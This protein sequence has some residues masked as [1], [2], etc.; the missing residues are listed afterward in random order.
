MTAKKKCGITL[1]FTNALSKVVGHEHGI[2]AD[3]LQKCRK[4]IETAH[5]TIEKT[6][7][8]GKLGFAKLPYT[9][10]SEID[11]II[12]IG[13]EIAQNFSDFVVLGIGGSALGNIALHSALNHP[14]Y[15]MLKT[16]SR[17][18]LFVL[19]NVDPELI[20]GALDVLPLEKTFFNVITKSGT[21]AET[22]SQYLIFQQM[23]KEHLGEKAFKRQFLF[24][25]DKEKGVLRKIASKENVRTLTIPDDAGGRF[26]VM[27]TV[28][29]LSAAVTGI[30]IKQLM[31]GARA[32]DEQ[33]REKDIYR[34]PA[35]MY[36]SLLYIMD[37]IKKK[38]MA[39]MMPY[40]Q[41]LRDLAD[42]YRQLLAESIGKKLDRQG[43]N[44][45][46]GQTPIKALGAT[47]QHSQVQ[48]YKE[49]PFDK[50]ITF[51]GV[52]QYRESIE[53]PSAYTDIEQLSYLCGKSLNT[54]IQAEQK[55]TEVALA[56][57][58]R[59]SCTITLDQLNPFTLGALMY[60][61]EYQIAIAGELYNINAFDQPG[62]EEGKDLTYGMMGRKGYEDKKALVEQ[63]GSQVSEDSKISF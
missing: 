38:P 25:T 48:L 9:P 6:K 60:M 13:S 61:L 36:T 40:V 4:Q 59:P 62:V 19:D 49:G 41:A 56:R 1:D 47:D 16:E 17:P 3:D 35:V 28:G 5:A 46:V 58:N 57:S 42:W 14:F 26:T 44:V 12:S 21:T 31:A 33:C 63:A 55:A 30:D 2:T 10:E 20:S 15:N 37:T 24:T 45:F 22:M 54:L 50:F 27:S 51:I 52:N 29:L 32:M 53:I 8:E 39:V 7:D 11:E 23:V 43:N 34:N 18:R